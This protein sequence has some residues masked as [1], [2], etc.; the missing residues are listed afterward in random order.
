MMSSA[1]S[2]DPLRTR[3]VKLPAKTTEASATDQGLKPWQF[4]VL[5]GMLSATAVVIVST[6]QSPASIIV[7][8]MTVV[9]TSL[10]ALGIYRA[11]SPLVLP[12]QAS[13][14]PALIGGRTRAALEREKTLTLR[15][16][17]ELE[18]DFAMRKV[19]QSDYDEMVG[20]LCVRAMGLMRQLEAGGGYKTAI[21]QELSA[22]LAGSNVGQS[23]ARTVTHT[24]ARD[25]SP[26]NDS[27]IEGPA[28]DAGSTTAVT[29]DPP[30]D[31]DDV[32]ASSCAACGTT[33]D[34][35]ARFC[36]N[37]GSKLSAA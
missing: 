37:C 14:P 15:S 23:V 10:V 34:H 9:S 20:K 21:E 25:F 7:L 16:I 8:S 3:A 1:T 13:E 32:A 11:L 36:K 27:G 33:N 5:A 22:R 2:I 24:V 6:G 4:F 28:N 31:R 30:A 19:S 29:D 12:P 26:A 17:K 35:D 18:F